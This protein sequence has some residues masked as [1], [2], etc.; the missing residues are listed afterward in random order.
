MQNRSLASLHEP[1]S[2]DT[3]IARIW[4]NVWLYLMLRVVFIKTTGF[5]SSTKITRDPIVLLEFQSR[6]SSCNN[7]LAWETFSR[8]QTA[9]VFPR[10]SEW[11]NFKTTSWIQSVKSSTYNFVPLEALLVEVSWDVYLR[12][13]NYK[14]R[15]CI[16]KCI[17]VWLFWKS[18]SQLPQKLKAIFLFIKTSFDFFV[19]W[20]FR[21]LSVS[22][23]IVFE[24]W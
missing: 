3:K 9:A 11:F 13:E 24:N 10:T 23:S 17:H 2:C 20:M 19:D 18:A 5:S 21:F 12:L 6:M 15:K 1:V 8:C 7:F 16:K 22:E 4:V 14:G